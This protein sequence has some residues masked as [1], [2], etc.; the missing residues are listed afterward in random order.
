MSLL[1]PLWGQGLILDDT[2]YQQL[3]TEF[4]GLKSLPPLHDTTDLSAFAPAVADQGRLP[5]CVPYALAYHAYTIQVARKFKLTN[6]RDI[7]KIALSASYVFGQLRPGCQTGLRLREVTDFLATRGDPF[8]HE[9]LAPPCQASNTELDNQL[10]ATN[11][12]VLPNPPNYGVR[13]VPDEKRWAVQ[14]TLDSLHKP[15]VLALS[16]ADF[17]LS[18]KDNF[19]RPSVQAGSSAEGHAVV[20]VGY[21][22]Q[23]QAFK[24]LNSHGAGFGEQGYF[25]LSYTDF[26]RYVRQTAV[27]NLTETNPLLTRIGA[28]FSLTD[29]TRKQPVL[30][31][32]TSPSQYEA[33]LDTTRL[34]DLICLYYWPGV[35][36]I[37]V[38]GIDRNGKRTLYFPR[39][40]DFSRFNPAPP[41]GVESGKLP[42]QTGSLLPEGMVLRGADLSYVGILVVSGFGFFDEV[43]AFLETPGQAEGPTEAHFLKAFGK[44]GTVTQYQPRQLSATA[45]PDKKRGNVVPF[46]I[47]IIADN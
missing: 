8:D 26:D 12:F 6:P 3:P 23:E 41:N 30:V 24:C 19:F 46:L 1:Q 2:L 4:V 18:R 22:N 36:E 35:R 44:P 43:S 5:M 31:R 33:R 45:L 42:A 39:N 38:F 21:D 10:A 7:Q 15:V 9:F 17:S 20:A 27:L 16:Q 47:K 40:R 28:D 37:Y 25:W 34:L 14:F 11:R 32:A 13:F 29:T